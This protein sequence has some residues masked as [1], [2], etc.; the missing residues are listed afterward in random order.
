MLTT[1]GVGTKLELA[2][3][4]NRWDGVGF[5][6][7]AMVVDDLAAAGATPLAVVDYMA[8]GALDPPTRHR[9]R[10]LDRRRLRRWPAAHCSVVRP[11]STPG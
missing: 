3:R 1:D 5:D 11:P 9:H 7:V 2:R 8:V 10:F 6:L 4:C